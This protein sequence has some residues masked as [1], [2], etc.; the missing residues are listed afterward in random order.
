[1]KALGLYIH[2]PFCVKKCSYC[3]F[4][5]FEDRENDVEQYIIA[6]K[7]EIATRDIERKS[8]YRNKNNIYRW[9]NPFIYKK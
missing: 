4:I 7:N 8:G 9:W 2:I 1:M 5:S 3:D 6:L